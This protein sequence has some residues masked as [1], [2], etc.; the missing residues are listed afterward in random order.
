MALNPGP[1]I[2]VGV[3]VGHNTLK[4]NDLNMSMVAVIISERLS[5]VW[6]TGRVVWESKGAGVGKGNPR[7]WDISMKWA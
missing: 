5:R 3:M 1:L 6:D 2:N 7:P 4:T